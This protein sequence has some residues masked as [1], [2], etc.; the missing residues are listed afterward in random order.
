LR[1]SYAH[2]IRDAAALMPKKRPNN[3]LVQ[4]LFGSVPDGEQI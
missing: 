2:L 4:A 3:T 1:T